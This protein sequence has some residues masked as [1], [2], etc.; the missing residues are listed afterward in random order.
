MRIFAFSGAIAA[1]LLA[2]MPV[3]ATNVADGAAIS[4]AISGNTVQGSMV[5][6]GVYTEF[7]A[8]DGEIRGDGYQ[9]ALSVRDDMM[10]FDYGDDPETCWQVRVDGDQVTWV[11]DDQELGTGTI[12]EGNANDF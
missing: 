6:S 4:A 8:D 3:L 1:T 7:Y 12:V 10:C 9:G 2:A 5:S 11:Q